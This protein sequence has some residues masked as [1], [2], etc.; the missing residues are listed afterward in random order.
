MYPKKIEKMGFQMKYDEAL[1][2]EQKRAKE[3]A[4]F[5]NKQKT[6]K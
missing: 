1:T 6:N 4:E 5:I 3:L 2:S